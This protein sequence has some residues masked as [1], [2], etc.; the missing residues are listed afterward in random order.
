[1]DAKV[2]SERLGH[3]KVAF[4]MDTYVHL[5]PGQQEEAAAKIE[6]A[7][8]AAREKLPKYVS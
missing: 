2:I 1:M 4:T 6:T 3:S 5:L 8:N 7:M